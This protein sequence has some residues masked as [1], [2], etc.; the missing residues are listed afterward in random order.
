MKF[1]H[2]TI[3]SYFAQLAVGTP[4]DV[5]Q[6]FAPDCRMVTAVISAPT[7]QGRAAVAD[8]YRTVF[9][10]GRPEFSNFRELVADSTI[11]VELVAVTAS[12]AIGFVDIFDLDDSGY[13]RTLSVYRRN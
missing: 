13:I 2:A 1:S 11:A 5:A 8:Y 10:N 12:G 7:L 9:T 4:E 6:T 3:N